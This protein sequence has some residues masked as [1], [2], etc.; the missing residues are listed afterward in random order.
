MNITNAIKLD[1]TTYAFHT[2]L[3]KVFIYMGLLIN[4]VIS[5]WIANKDPAMDEEAIS[6]LGKL[7][8]LTLYLDFINLFS[9]LLRIFGNRRSN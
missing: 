3:N 8:V 6:K 4:A 9:S 5:Y 1:K 2:L 7:G